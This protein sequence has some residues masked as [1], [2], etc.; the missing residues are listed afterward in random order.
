MLPGPQNVGTGSTKLLGQRAAVQVWAESKDFDT[1]FVDFLLP[2][3]VS[4]KLISGL[5]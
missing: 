3:L 1:L 5:M 2:F 4:E